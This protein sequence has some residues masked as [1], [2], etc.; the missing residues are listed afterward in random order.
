MENTEEIQK[1]LKN[2]E[3]TG[4]ILLVED[5]PGDALLAMEALKD[6]KHHNELIWVR[7]GMEAMDYLH[8]V[9]KYKNADYPDIILLDLNLPS[10]DGKEVLREIKSNNDL[11][12]IPVIILTISSSEDDII[13][14]YNLQANS[15]ITK[16]I[17]LEEFINVIKSIEYYWFSIVKLP[18]NK[19]NI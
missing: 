5:N 15:Y 18:K 8:K 1:T 6:S 4:T 17:D 16:P 13:K 7:D 9:G 12:Q 11:K 10:K 3:K 2:E 14:S 19:S